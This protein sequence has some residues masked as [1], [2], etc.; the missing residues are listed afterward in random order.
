MKSVSFLFFVLFFSLSHSQRKQFEK[1]FGTTNSK[2]FNLLIKDFEKNILKKKFPNVKIAQAY[3]LFLKSYIDNKI[4]L[5]DKIYNYGNE[6]L[7]KDNFKLKIYRVL[8]S[9]WV[10]KPVFSKSNDT[11][12]NARYKYLNIKKEIDYLFSEMSVE[13]ISRI[14]REK[15]VNLNGIYF[16]SLENISHKVNIL[17]GYFEDVYYSGAFLNKEV[18]AENI[19][20][21]KVDTNNYFVKIAILTNIVYL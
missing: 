4:N 21:N 20:S 5:K 14:F 17:R 13:K 10:G 2:N 16:K 19:L 15:D 8:D 3:K 7:E 18:L 6:I 12:F 11:V 9:T 1:E